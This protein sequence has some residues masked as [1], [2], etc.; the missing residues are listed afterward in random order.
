MCASTQWEMQKLHD[1]NPIVDA[2][3]WKLF[4][5]NVNNRGL[6]WTFTNHSKQV[7][8]MDMIIKIVGSKIETTLFEKPIAFSL[9]LLASQL[10]LYLVI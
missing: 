7:D 1:A 6:N 5:D 3:I 8:F 10:H 4:K 2:P 9:I